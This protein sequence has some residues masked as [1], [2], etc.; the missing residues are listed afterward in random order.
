MKLFREEQIL[1]LAFRQK[2][3]EEITSGE[4]LARKE[5]ALKRH[6]IYRDNTVKWVIKQLEREGLKPETI[7]MMSNRA[8]N[9]SVCRKIVNKLARCYMGG[10]NRTAESDETTQQIDQLSRL[11]CLDQKLKKADRY[12]ELFR[13]NLVQIIPE[14]CAIESREVQKYKLKPRVLAPWQY[15][16]IEDWYDHERPRCIILSEY[17][18]RNVMLYAQPGSDGRG[19]K[20]LG[21]VSDGRDQIIA[22]SPMD[23][24]LQTFIWWSDRYHFTTDKEG[25]VLKDYSPEDLLNP[26][27]MLPFANV[28]TDQDGE[29]WAQGGND[30][31]D[32]S[33]LVNTLLTDM[34]SILNVQGWGQLVLTGKNIPERLTVGPHQALVINQDDGDP[35]PSVDFISAQSQVDSWMAAIEQYVALLLSTNG[36]SPTNIAGKLSASEFPSGISLLIEQSE[37]T[38]NVE[39]EQKQFVDVE[40]KLWKV[41]ALWQNLLFDADALTDEFME[42]GQVNMDEQIT[43]KFNQTKPVI[44]EK[45]KLEILKV[46]K[47]LGLNTELDLIKLDNPDLT[48][49]EA[50]S[51][52]LEIKEEKLKK[53]SDAMVRSLAQP[54]PAPGDQGV[55]PNAPTPDG[56]KIGDGTD[57]IVVNKSQTLVN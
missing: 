50:E 28:T 54:K 34:F 2:V 35:Q 53:L 29:Y 44:T 36:L 20:T 4:N 46:R 21:T 49:E 31:I 16:A 42:V 10:V 40:R 48:D 19:A 26:I 33:I 24:Q 15:D 1:D 11:L 22:D 47:E 43:I 3:I 12:R 5:E 14:Y 13:N 30:L 9:I 18:D 25:E 17:T 52:L 39:D 51:K 56:V 37:A 38:G 55:D 32:G 7:A 45:E 57:Q 6:E 41:T 8:A 23:S 27:E